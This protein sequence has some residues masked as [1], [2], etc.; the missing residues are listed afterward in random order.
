MCFLPQ[1]G[2]CL[3]ILVLRSELGDILSAYSVGFII[4]GSTI[5]A[6]GTFLK[7]DE[8]QLMQQLL[9]GK[10][11]VNININAEKSLVCLFISNKDI[12]L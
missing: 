3:Y 12:Y 1:S 9:G 10:R 2:V 11:F 6:I 4:Q 5:S 8:F 7:V